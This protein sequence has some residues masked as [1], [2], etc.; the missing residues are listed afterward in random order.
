MNLL[1]QKLMEL[2]PPL[3]NTEQMEPINIKVICKFFNPIGS[4]TWYVTEYDGENTFFGFVNLGDDD[5]A[6]LGYFSKSELEELQLPL[7]LRIERDLYW[8]S[9]TTLSEVMMKLGK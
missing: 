2:I 9:N 1:T 3:Y 7:G 6:E 4:Q 5:N 8:D